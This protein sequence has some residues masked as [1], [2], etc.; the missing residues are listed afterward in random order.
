MTLSKH[1][2]GENITY[3]LYICGLYPTRLL[4]QWGFSRQEYWSG[5][6]CPPPG[7][8]SNPGIKPRSPTLQTDSL[9]SES[10]GKPKNTGVGNLLFSRVSSSPRN[11]VCMYVYVCIC[12]C[13]YMYV[14]VCMYVCMK[15]LLSHFSCAW[16]CEPMDCSTPGFPV[17]HQLPEL[18]QTHVHRASDAIQSP[19]PLSSPSPPT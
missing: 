18:T 5:L 9:P 2:N 13:M 14:Y 16:L 12:I 7:D 19:H 10:P 1:Q 17:H 3:I 15:W 4:C 8:L 6:P 11:S